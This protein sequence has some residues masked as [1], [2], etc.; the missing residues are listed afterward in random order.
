MEAN[1]RTRRRRSGRVE[2]TTTHT[3]THTDFLPIGT[4]TIVMKAKMCINKKKEKKKGGEVDWSGAVCACRTLLI[5]YSRF[6]PPS[7]TQLLL[8]PFF[9]R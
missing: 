9:V 1:E 7:L 2:N 6:R 8:L 3:H 5:C 4:P